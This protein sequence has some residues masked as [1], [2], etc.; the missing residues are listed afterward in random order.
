MTFDSSIA[1]RNSTANRELNI[2][3]TP[4]SD[5]CIPTEGEEWLI[6]EDCVL[7]EHII[8]LCPAGVHIVSGASLTINPSSIVIADYLVMDV[9]TVLVSDGDWLRTC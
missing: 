9:S 6:E 4:A 8:N 1:Q 3:L 7:A 2:T 5:N